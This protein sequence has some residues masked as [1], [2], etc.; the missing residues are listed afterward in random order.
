MAE[1]SRN[2]DDLSLRAFRYIAGELS[3]ADAAAFERRL[4]RDLDGCAAVAEMVEITGAIALIQPAPARSTVSRRSPA[5]FHSRFRTRLAT[6]F[7][8]SIAIGVLCLATV[9]S[10]P[11][12]GPP[13]RTEGMEDA[14]QS[15]ALTWSSLRQQHDGALFAD[16]GDWPLFEPPASGLTRTALDP[17]ED[18]AALPSWVL[19]SIDASEEPGEDGAGGN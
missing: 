16:L 7:A 2:D 18:D 3:E 17:R 4:A 10:T 19:A 5:A 1:W 13:D 15:V 6:A 12:P 9:S 11:R 14:P 8:A